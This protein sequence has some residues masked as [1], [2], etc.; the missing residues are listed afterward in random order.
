VSKSSK[1]DLLQKTNPASEFLNRK[2]FFIFIV[3]SS[4]AGSFIYI[5][6][7]TR[8]PKG[9]SGIYS[10]TSFI[11]GRIYIG[12]AINL[13]ERKIDHFASLKKGNHHN[14]YLQNHYNKYKKK[15]LQFSIVE[16]CLKENLI[17]REQYYIDQIPK[18]LKFNIAKK[19]N[20]VMFGRNH[21]KQAIK[22]QRKARKVFWKTHPE[23]REKMKGVRRRK[24]GNPP[25]HP[26]KEH[27]QKI[28]EAVSKP[29]YQYDLHGNFIA[30]YESQKEAALQTGMK[31]SGGI[32]MCVNNK[33]KTAGGY[34]W[35][36]NKSC[37]NIKL[38]TNN[39]SKN[40]STLLMSCILKRKQPRLSSIG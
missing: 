28:K 39:K 27:L 24:K 32:S 1:Y 34:I 17:Q 4:G 3:D 38:N 31:S 37:I 19:A 40:Q 11:K 12:S 13:R 30:K 15:D 18:K 6:K 8:I 26:S 9:K 23:Y 2:R 14:T 16:F 20:S 35:V 5:M 25:F 21:S 33:V 7:R 22:K 29:V 10:I 36:N